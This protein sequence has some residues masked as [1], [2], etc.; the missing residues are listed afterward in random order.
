MDPRILLIF[1]GFPRLALTR[2]AGRVARMHI[3]RFMRRRLWAWLGRKLH[4]EAKDIPGD[5]RDYATFLELFTRPLA[6]YR[7]DI[8]S[9]ES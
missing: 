9:G 7:P 2:L 8:P 3:P 1:P 4:I 6:D 5:L